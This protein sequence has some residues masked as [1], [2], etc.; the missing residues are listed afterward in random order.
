MEHISHNPSNPT[1]DPKWEY[2]FDVYFELGGRKVAIEV[3]DKVGH[4]STRS[5]QK[6]EIKKR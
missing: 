1:N 3:D 6:R 5:F 4:S 2:K